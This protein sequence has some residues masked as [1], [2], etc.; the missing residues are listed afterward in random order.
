VQTWRLFVQIRLRILVALGAVI[1]VTPLT[2]N[3]GLTQLFAPL[4]FFPAP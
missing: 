1:L 3:L 4:L 2:F